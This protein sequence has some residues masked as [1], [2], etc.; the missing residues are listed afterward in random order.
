[1]TTKRKIPGAAVPFLNPDG[2][3]QRDWYQYLLNEAHVG[4][5]ATAGSAGGATL[6]ATPEGFVTIQVN[7]VSVLQPYYL[8]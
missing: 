3:V 4:E 8:P 7:G 1:M 5:P 2:T 6:P